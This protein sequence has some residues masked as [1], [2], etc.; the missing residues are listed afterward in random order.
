MRIRELWS[1]VEIIMT[2]DVSNKPFGTDDIDDEG[3]EA[4]LGVDFLQETE[5][6]LI[7]VSN[8]LDDY[9]RPGFTVRRTM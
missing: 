2:V 1:G 5:C 4:I 7:L 9:L 6:L 8:T 3:V